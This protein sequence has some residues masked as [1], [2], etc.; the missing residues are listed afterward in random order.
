MLVHVAK[1]TFLEA[2]T[3]SPRGGTAPA[4]RREG[5]APSGGFAGW[6]VGP[7]RSGL[8][9]PASP[10][11]SGV[12][13]LLCGGV[14]CCLLTIF[15]HL[16]VRMPNGFWIWIPELLNPVLI[17][18]SQAA[19]CSSIPSSSKLDRELFDPELLEFLENDFG[20]GAGDVARCQLIERMDV[21][22]KLVL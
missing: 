21:A 12:V 8:V 20:G 10:S 15:T 11:V 9:S 17:Y 6:C 16:H 5:R 2:V 7:D 1:P 14:S 19:P 4:S 22:E 13:D 18:G 3:P